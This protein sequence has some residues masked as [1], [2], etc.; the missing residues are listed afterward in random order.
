MAMVLMAASSAMANT[1]P[2]RSDTCRPPAQ[3][4]HPLELPPEP[5]GLFP[6]SQPEAATV[7]VHVQVAADGSVASTRV[8]CHTAAHHR[9]IQAALRAVHRGRFQARQAPYEGEI[10]IDFQLGD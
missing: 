10:A 9:T 2:G 5:F 1:L 7:I 4:L 8:T 3:P 6:E